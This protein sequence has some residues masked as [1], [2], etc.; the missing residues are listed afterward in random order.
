MARR[1][2]AFALSVEVALMVGGA[3]LT[4]GVYLVIRSQFPLTAC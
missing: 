2:V 3:A 1:I 4:V